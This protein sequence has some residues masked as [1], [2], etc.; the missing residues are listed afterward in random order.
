MLE[1]GN[2]GFVIAFSVILMFVSPDCHE[3]AGNGDQ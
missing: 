2:L 1:D 3:E